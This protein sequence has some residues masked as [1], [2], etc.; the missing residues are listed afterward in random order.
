[1]LVHNTIMACEK[2]GTPMDHAKAFQKIANQTNCV[3]SSRSVGKAATG[4]LLEGYATKGFHVK[5]KSC[6]WGPMAGFVLSDPRFTKRGTSPEAYGAQQKDLGKAFADGASE[7]PLMISDERRKDVEARGW[8]TR[9]GGNIAE[10]IYSAAA[11][12]GTAINFVLVRTD[13]VPGAK[14]KTMWAVNYQ[15]GE[16]KVAPGLA[17]A[18]IVENDRVPVMAMVDP[19]PPAHLKNSYRRAMTGD[20]DLWAVFPPAGKFD[21]RKGGPDAR[22][23]PG[24]DRFVVPARTFFAHEHAHMG[25]ITGRVTEVKNLLNDAIRQAGYTGG[26]AVHHSDEAGRPFV[27]EVEMNFIAFVPNDPNAYFISNLQ[28]LGAF[29][30]VVIRGWHVTFNPG[31]QK[32]LGFATTSAGNWEV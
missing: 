32:Q 30:R 28:D 17:A 11:K 16:T 4:L 15:R 6:D 23:V 12:G 7:V 14:G 18:K 27:T 20:Y 26:D 5:A 3:I 10:P 22:M 24:S 21:A 29:M 25:N 31:W 9:A 8:M 19:H 1:M 2:S 13:N